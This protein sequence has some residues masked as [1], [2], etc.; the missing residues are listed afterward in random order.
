M[1]NKMIYSRLKARCTLHN[2]HHRV[3]IMVGVGAAGAGVGYYL[4]LALLG[5]VHKHIR[6][7]QKTEIWNSY[8]RE[9]ESNK[10]NHLFL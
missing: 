1:P 2:V 10:Y 7:S 3:D 5:Q 6:L 8:Q 4:T 9:R